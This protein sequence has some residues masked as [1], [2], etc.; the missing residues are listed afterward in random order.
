[1]QMQRIQQLQL[2]REQMKLRQQEIL[3]QPAFGLSTNVSF[4][5]LSIS[6]SWDYLFELADLFERRFVDS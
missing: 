5:L 1:M 4:I 3:R 6:S 2:E